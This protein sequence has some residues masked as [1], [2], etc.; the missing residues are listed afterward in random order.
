MLSAIVL[1]CFTII[2][3]LFSI[4]ATIPAQNPTVETAPMVGARWQPLIIVP[5]APMVGAWHKHP[6][7]GVN[8][9]DFGNV[10]QARK[11]MGMQGHNS[12]PDVMAEFLRVAPRPKARL[13]YNPL[14]KQ[15]N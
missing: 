2:A 7:A 5:R 6:L 8:P 9:K 1:N 10:W 3:I 4:C 13:I 15:V 11:A 12:A 14:T